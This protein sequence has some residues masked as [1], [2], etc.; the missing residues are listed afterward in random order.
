M[1]GVEES[2]AISCLSEFARLSP[3]A[4]SKPHIRSEG[5]AKP[6]EKAEHT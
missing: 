6:D 2:G 3:E 1:L 4:I 5:K